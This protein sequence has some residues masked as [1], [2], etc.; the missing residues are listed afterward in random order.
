MPTV[1]YLLMGVL[2]ELVQQPGGAGAAGASGLP[3]GQLPK[4]GPGLGGCGGLGLVVQGALQA[5]KAVLSS[6]MSRAEKSRGAWSHLLRC[7]LNTLLDCWDS[8]TIIYHT[9]PSG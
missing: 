6:P 7:A 5:L 3:G 4:P 8:G 9:P 1:L 2:R